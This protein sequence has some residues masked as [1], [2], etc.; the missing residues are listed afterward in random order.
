MYTSNVLHRAGPTSA[1][2]KRSVNLSKPKQVM[3]IHQFPVKQI[4]NFIPTTLA[5]CQS[6]WHHN[7]QNWLP[8][9]HKTSLT[10]S[11]PWSWECG[12][13]E[14]ASKE[15]VSKNRASRATQLLTWVNCWSFRQLGYF[16]TTFHTKLLFQL[17]C[18]NSRSVVNFKVLPY[19]CFSINSSQ[20]KSF[21][22]GQTFCRRGS[23]ISSQFQI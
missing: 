21:I 5:A 17:E 12:S 3:A 9:M 4:F 18:W 23:R 15:N 8:R 10:N 2:K 1:N 22:L 6:V 19:V 7:H 11:L 13:W 20:F 14:V 16:Q